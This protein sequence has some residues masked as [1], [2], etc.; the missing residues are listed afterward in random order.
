MSSSEV[1]LPF[2]EKIATG[3]F[4]PPLSFGSPKS[5]DSAHQSVRKPKQNRSLA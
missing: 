5:N 1:D 3:C 2:A 4:R